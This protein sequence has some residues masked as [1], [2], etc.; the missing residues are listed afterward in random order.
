MLKRHGDKA[1]EQ[2][3]TRIDELMADGDQNAPEM[4]GRFYLIPCRAMFLVITSFS[5]C[6]FPVNPV[7]RSCQ[8]RGARQLHIVTVV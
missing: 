3:R 7:L 8:K 4:V 5:D 6:G 2:S 1:L